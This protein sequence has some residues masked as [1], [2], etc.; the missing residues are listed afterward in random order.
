MP[1]LF[2]RSFDNYVTIGCKATYSEHVINAAGGDLTT[3]PDRC[4]ACLLLLYRGEVAKRIAEKHPEF[5]DLATKVE[6]NVKTYR[7]LREAVEEEFNQAAAFYQN[8]QFQS[9]PDYLIFMVSA[10]SYLYPQDEDALKA[11]S[12]M[13]G[14]LDQ[15][16]DTY[17]YANFLICAGLWFADYN[18]YRAAVLDRFPAI[19]AQFDAERAAKD[20]PGFIQRNMDTLAKTALAVL[21]STGWDLENQPIEYA[22]LQALWN[23]R[24]KLAA[25]IAGRR[26]EFAG[27][28]S[29]M[30]QN[31]AAVSAPDAPGERITTSL[32]DEMT[33][34]TKFYATGDW[35]SD[36]DYLALVQAHA[37]FSFCRDADSRE[38][39]QNTRMEVFRQLEKAESM[40]GG[41]KVLLII[42]LWFEDYDGFQGKVRALLPAFLQEKRTQTWA[43][44][45]DQ[46]AEQQR[47]LEER[48][49]Q[50]R[51][52]GVCQHCG[53]AFKGLLTKKCVSC[54]RTKDY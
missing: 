53:G 54:G 18:G 11:R 51:A 12:N 31:N 35:K 46:Q 32:G 36:M 26:P 28:L 25:E 8:P 29:L 45:R 19:K 27:V 14:L 3:E 39:T 37:C 17:G 30:K 13:F 42:A 22:F 9:D 43:R 33:A 15:A 5:A 38:K 47:Q 23:Y 2:E 50:Y 52:R 20:Q 16:E 48:R 4:F 24:T 6:E 10:I 1:G 40:S 44:E 34:M 41:G 21:D 7:N 49:A